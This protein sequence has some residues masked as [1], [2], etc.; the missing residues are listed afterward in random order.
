MSYV[1]VGYLLSSYIFSVFW[2]IGYSLKWDMDS[3][4]LESNWLTPTS[5][6]ALLVGRT[7]SDLVITTLMNGI[8]LLLAWSLFG[9]SISGNLGWALLVAVPMLLALYGFGF[10]F[11]AI[12]L[13]MR[14]ANT[15]VD[16]SHYLISLLSGDQFPVHVL[17]AWLLPLSLMIPLTYGFDAVRG[18]LLQTVTLL[19]IRYEIAILVLFMVIMLPTGYWVFKVVERRCKRL[20][21]LGMH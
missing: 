19:P 21:T 2:M 14:D 5:R 12:I 20:G 16:V 8:L 13:V 3:G 7:F 15:M 10:A 17:P 1:V 18:L 4:V 6:F 9:F 11:A